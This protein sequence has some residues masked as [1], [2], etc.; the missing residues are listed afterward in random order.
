MDS[1]DAVGA[2]TPSGGE[3]AW[4]AAAAAAAAVA[5]VQGAR[6]AA[7][8]RCTPGTAWA[9]A[10]RA[11]KRVPVTGQIWS[12]VRHLRCTTTLLG[13]H[14]NALSPAQRGRSGSGVGTMLPVTRRRGTD[15]VQVRM[16]CT[17]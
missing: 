6:G 3:E 12:S 11:P 15:R 13:Y 2:D 16:L 9:A 7:G 1:A 10:W 5:P 4:P 8:C 17:R 14:A